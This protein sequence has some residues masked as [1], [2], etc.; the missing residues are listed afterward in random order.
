MAWILGGFGALLVLFSFVAY[1]AKI[2]NPPLDER[3][4]IIAMV[5]LLAAAL[6]AG[7][8]AG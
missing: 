7:I 3:V 6:V 8:E 1:A 2:S 4:S 5:A